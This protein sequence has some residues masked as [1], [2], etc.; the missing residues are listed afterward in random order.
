LKKRKLKLVLDTN[1][2][3]SAMIWGGSP[4]RII[5]AAEK[6]IVCLITSDEILDEISR[7]LMRP[8]LKRSCDL[9]GISQQQVTEAV[10][11]LS[12]LVEVKSKIHVVREDPADDKV[13]EC[14]VDSKA[15]YIVSGD[16]HLL[17][18]GSYKKTR[19]VSV[20]QFLKILE[21]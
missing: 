17:K 21:K 3:V 7:T 11:R 20:R 9:K 18:I 1:V 12:M 10:L 8:K 14:A 2:W 19:I 5:E 16:N 4:A 6:R 15:D 13:I